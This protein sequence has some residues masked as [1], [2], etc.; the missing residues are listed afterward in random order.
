VEQF[1]ALQSPA[2]NGRDGAA[3]APWRRGAGSFGVIRRFDATRLLQRSRTAEPGSH[4][5][6]FLCQRGS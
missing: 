2:Q 3:I 6:K 5:T 4:T 1:L